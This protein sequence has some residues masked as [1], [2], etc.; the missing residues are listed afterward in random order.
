LN[1][2]FQNLFFKKIENKIVRGINNLTIIANGDCADC[3]VWRI[4][5]LIIIGSVEHVV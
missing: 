3:V 2:N 1:N 5:N 4:N